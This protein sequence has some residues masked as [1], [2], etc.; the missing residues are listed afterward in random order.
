MALL[1]RCQT[2]GIVVFDRQFHIH[3]W[4]I[5]ITFTHYFLLSPFHLCRYPSS[6]L[7]AFWVPYPSLDWSFS[8]PQSEELMFVC[9]GWKL[10]QFVQNELMVVFSPE[11]EVYITLSKTQETLLMRIWRDSKGWK[12]RRVHREVHGILVVLMSIQQLW[13]LLP[14][15]L[16]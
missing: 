15:L 8:H 16:R 10:I 9:S 6:H 13:L 5:L 4:Y 11:W 7:Y 12:T 1:L 14:F 2:P 3:V